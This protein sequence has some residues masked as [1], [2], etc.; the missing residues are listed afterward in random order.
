LRLR[1]LRRIVQNDVAILINLALNLDG[2]ETGLTG[3]KEG[4]WVSYHHTRW[5]LIVRDVCRITSPWPILFKAFT[6][7]TRLDLVRV[8]L[9]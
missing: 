9:K 1:A 2:M 8:L 5:L 7:R 4:V 6:H 3:S